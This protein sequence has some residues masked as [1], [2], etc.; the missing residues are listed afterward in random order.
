MLTLDSIVQPASGVVTRASGDELVVVSPAKGKYVVLNETGASV[1][2]QM[3]GKVALRA[4]AEQLALQYQIS[5][6][7]AQ[8]DTLALAMQLRDREI[9]VVS[10][11]SA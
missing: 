2:R 1:F 9:V 4:I 5:L 6:E 7:R 10:E 3:D 8:A 11:T